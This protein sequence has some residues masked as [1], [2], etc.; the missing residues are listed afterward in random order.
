MSKSYNIAVIPGDGTGP[1]VVREGIKVLNAAAARFGF[2]LNLTNFD[3]GGER[4]KAHRRD[5][6]GFRRWRNCAS[7]IRF[8]GRDGH[9]RVKPAFSKGHFA[10]GPFELDQYINLRRSSCILLSNVR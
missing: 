10:E 1:E 6:A 5:P 4:Y 2:A 8:P 9:S 7:S 3:F